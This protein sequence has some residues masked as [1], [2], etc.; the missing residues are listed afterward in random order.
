MRRPPPLKNTNV[1]EL[2]NL[3]LK[4]EEDRQRTWYNSGIGTYAQWSW[5][6]FELGRVLY[7]QIDSAVALYV[8]IFPCTISHFIP[9][10]TH[11]GVLKRRSYLRTGGYLTITNMAIVFFFLVSCST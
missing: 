5:N 10:F 1:I 8:Q 9:S 7:N 4:G 3:I 6:P 2:Y 11:V